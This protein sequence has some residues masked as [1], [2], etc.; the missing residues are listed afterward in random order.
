MEPTKARPSTPRARTK[1]AESFRYV[2][3]CWYVNRSPRPGFRRPA[4]KVVDSGGRSACRAKMPAPDPVAVRIAVDG[5]ERCV[6][7]RL[8]R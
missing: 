2:A 8:G 4:H 5:D 7:C 3:G 1:E 6:S